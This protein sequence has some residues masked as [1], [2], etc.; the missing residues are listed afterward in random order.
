[1]IFLTITS[2]HTFKIDHGYVYLFTF[3]LSGLVA[4][5]EKSGGLAGFAN[6]LEP[7]AKTSKSGQLLAFG[8]GLVIFFDDYANTLVVGSMFRPIVDNLSVSCEKLAFLVD[9]TA[10]PIASIVRKR[11]KMNLIE[12]NLLTIFLHSLISLHFYSYFKLDRI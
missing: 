12:N 10:A 6:A 2:L 5:M 3:F 11:Q 1:M 8:A 4:L 9:A 7:Y